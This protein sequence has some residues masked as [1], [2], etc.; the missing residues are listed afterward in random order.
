MFLSS[1]AYSNVN[2]PETI[3]GF[4]SATS[5]LACEID[6]YFMD[7][8]NYSDT[9]DT[10]VF[11]DYLSSRIKASKPYD[12]IVLSDDEAL[13][14]G[15]QYKDDLFADIPILFLGV[16]NTTRGRNAAEQENV[17]GLLE[18]PDYQSNIDLMRTLFPERKELYIIID[19]STT[20]QAEYREIVKLATANT[21]FHF[22]T[23][24]TASYLQ[25]DLAAIIAT[26]GD[27]GIIL[28]LD[29]TGD[30]SKT[31]YTFTSAT[32]FL[33]ANAPD[34]PI[35]RVNS[36]NAG[37]GIFGGISYSNEHSGYLAGVIAVELLGGADPDTFALGTGHVTT[38]Y[39][40][41]R[42]LDK[43]GIKVRDLPADS[44]IYNEHEDF[45]YFYRT[46]HLMVNLVLVSIAL[47]ILLIIILFFF[48][49]RS[50]KLRN[51]D[52][53][54]KVPNRNWIT[55]RIDHEI[56][57]RLDG[58]N[59]RFG[60]VMID[61]D[62]FKRINDTLG[63]AVGDELLIG[64]ASR[65]KTVTSDSFTIARIGG[66]EFIGLMKNADK[67]KLEAK[68]V[69]IEAIMKAPFSLSTGELKITTSMGG[70][71]CPDDTENPNRIMAYADAAMYEIKLHG[72]NGHALYKPEY[73]ANLEKLK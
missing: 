2:V 44:I 73:K 37:H 47:L 63:H 16:N 28:Y 14:F 39:F 68:C 15:M 35:F 62:N 58:R 26:I 10:S 59:N 12:L 32:E 23:I 51:E 18:V 6:Y 49:R 38:P 54:T 53:L 70:A 55:Q 41:R 66:D 5:S 30:R 40:D 64:F 65:L 7:S 4:E 20:G 31:Y 11:Y 3:A 9:D 48:N 34:V 17:V 29:F 46:H 13:V 52:F 21:D 43:F 33:A 27:D 24:N 45:F 71:V 22:H 50:E 1:F 57:K 60:I 67:E 61:I 72:K 36:A 69:E 8:H 56:Q 42:Q 19:N 25:S